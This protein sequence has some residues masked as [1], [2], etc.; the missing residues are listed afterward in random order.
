M[1]R[2]KLYISVNHL[3]INYLFL[4]TKKLNKCGSGIMKLYLEDGYEIDEDE[5]LLSPIASDK[6]LIISTVPPN[7]QDQINTG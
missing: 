6:T 4:V 5:I 2:M 1:F 7:S 3:H